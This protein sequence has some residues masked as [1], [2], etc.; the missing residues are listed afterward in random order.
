VSNT[1]VDLLLKNKL[2]IKIQNLF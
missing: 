1:D 2:K